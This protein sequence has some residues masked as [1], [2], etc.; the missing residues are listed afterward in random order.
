MI[1]AKFDL[2]EFDRACKQIVKETGKIPA[3]VTN[4]ALFEVGKIATTTT[5]F[6]PKEQILSELNRDNLAAKLVQAK[7]KREG[8]K[9]LFGDALTA[10]AE[11]LKRLRQRGSKVV[12]GGFKTA[13]KVIAPFVKKKGGAVPAGKVGKTNNLGG[14]QPAREGNKTVGAIWNSY[15]GG[16]SPNSVPER[17]TNEEYEGVVKAARIKLADLNDYLLQLAQKAANKFH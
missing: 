11:K 3:D 17:V 15:V 13:I 14:G 8:K 6:T 5:K 4:K 9:G 12:L 1:K 10:A 2:R 16:K 7:L